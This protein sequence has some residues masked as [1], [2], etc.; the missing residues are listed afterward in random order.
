MLTEFEFFSD[1]PQVVVRLNCQQ[2]LITELYDDAGH[3]SL[4]LD[5][6]LRDVGVFGI[7]VIG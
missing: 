6:G 1:M 7:I 4:F 2:V 5:S 3:G